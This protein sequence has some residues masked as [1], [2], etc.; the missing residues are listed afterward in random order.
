[1]A[2]GRSCAPTTSRGGSAGRCRTFATWWPRTRVQRAAKPNFASPRSGEAGGSCLPTSGE[3]GVLAQQAHRVG[4][5][6]S[7]KRLESIPNRFRGSHRL[8]THRHRPPG[9]EAHDSRG[10]ARTWSY[11]CPPPRLRGA[12]HQPRPPLH[13]FQ[14]S[15]LVKPVLRLAVEG[16]DSPP[17]ALRTPTSPLRGEAMLRPPTECPRF[18]TRRAAHADLPTAW[19]GDAAPAY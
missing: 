1:M 9:C 6:S 12:D 2:R 11:A 3:A 8:A 18:P 15:S 10:L 5:F 16:C 19:G 4:K 17:G 14:A 7:Q 13:P